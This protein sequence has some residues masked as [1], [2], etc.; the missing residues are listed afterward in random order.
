[1]CLYKKTHPPVPFLKAV[2]QKILKQGTAGRQWETT[3]E[4]QLPVRNLSFFFCGP[5]PC[6]FILQ[7]RKCLKIAEHPCLLHC[8]GKSIDWMQVED[9]YIPLPPQAP[10]QQNVQQL[11]VMIL[12][13]FMGLCLTPFWIIY[14][15]SKEKLQSDWLLREGHQPGMLGGQLRTPQVQCYDHWYSSE[16]IL[17]ALNIGP[18]ARLLEAN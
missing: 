2:I 5:T 9:R 11:Y 4:E 1:M 8:I 14:L 3:L 12:L 18:C 16:K 10:V 6:T 13:Q 7:L 15:K 17:L